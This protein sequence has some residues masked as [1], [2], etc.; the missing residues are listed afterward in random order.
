MLINY[1]LFGFAFAGFCS[2]VGSIHNSSSVISVNGMFYIIGVLVMG[3]FLSEATAQL[4]LH[5][6]ISRFRVIA[7]AGFLAGATANP[8]YLASVA[9]VVDIIMMIMEF[10]MN[11]K[12]LVC[13][14][15]WMTTHIL[16]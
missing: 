14:K 11:K 8:I 6:K 4:L 15:S 2:L 5:K 3:V 16:A 1:F 12:T 9:M 10:C 13:P 7:K